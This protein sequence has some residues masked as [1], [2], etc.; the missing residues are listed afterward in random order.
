[1][2]KVINELLDRFESQTP[3]LQNQ[4]N[5][6]SLIA[7]L[8][9]Q[10]NTNFSKDKDGVES[11]WAQLLCNYKS[12]YNRLNE[13][14]EQTDDNASLKTLV[15]KFPMSY[16]K[17]YNFTSN[18]FKN[19]FDANFVMK[20]WLILPVT[21]EKQSYQYLND[22]RMPIKNQTEVTIDPDFDLSKLFEDEL[23]P[24]K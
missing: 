6:L 23:K 24:K 20:Q 1:M 3:T 17:K 15:I 9:I 18:Q 12:T 13:N 14:G 21:E 10:A 7:V 2:S 11:Y 8:A 4:F 19:R 16:L 5:R 22:K